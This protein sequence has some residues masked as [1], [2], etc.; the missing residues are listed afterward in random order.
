MSFTAGYSFGLIDAALLLVRVVVGSFFVLYRFRWVYDPTSDQ[1][2]FCP[3]RRSRL[4]E[5]IR[6]CRYGCSNI[7]PALVAIGEI[8]AGFALIIGLLSLP[9]A[10]L[11]LVILLFGMVCLLPEEIPAMNPVDRIDV[12]RCTMQ[13]PEPLYAVLCVVVLLA[14]PGQWSID[15]LL[16]VVMP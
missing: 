8:G 9:S 13:W 1:R 16:G 12:V 11:L 7:L 6:A 4:K 5:R 3:V 15:A 10:A 2:W 14:G